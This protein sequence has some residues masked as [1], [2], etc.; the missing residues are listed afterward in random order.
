MNINMSFFIEYRLMN[1][2]FW[3]YKKVLTKFF[4]NFPHIMNTISNYKP[5]P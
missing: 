1:S 4:I 5:L 2:E 3:L